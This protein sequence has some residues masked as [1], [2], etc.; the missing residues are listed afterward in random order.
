MF[1]FASL[2][3][4]T[5]NGKEK[6]NKSNERNKSFCPRKALVIKISL[7]PVPPVLKHVTGFLIVL[8]LTATW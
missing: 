1:S 5:G 8:G 6:A 2:T 3:G 4:Q 7:S